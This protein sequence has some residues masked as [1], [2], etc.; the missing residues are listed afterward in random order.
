MVL[1][2]PRDDPFDCG[3]KTTH[4]YIPRCNSCTFANM[5]NIL[6]L[7]GIDPPQWFADFLE[8]KSANHDYFTPT[9][10]PLSWATS[11]KLVRMDVAIY[12]IHL[13]SARVAFRGFGGIIS[14]LRRLASNKLSSYAE[15]KVLTAS[16]AST[17]ANQVIAL[18]NF[19]LG[20]MQA[21]TIER[22]KEAKIRV[23]A[24]KI[25]EE[26]YFQNT[27]RSSRRKRRTKLVYSRHK[28]APQ[29]RKPNRRWKSP[30]S[31]R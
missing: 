27:L 12:A 30:R 6:T 29:T 14:Q 10:E 1:R 24:R 2:Y 7:L 26:V 28:T 16:E 8:R 25:L 13:M 19:L 15:N 22:D 18:G 20:I 9:E 23:G 3:Q 21:T 31:T 11:G 4:G 17:R 5:P